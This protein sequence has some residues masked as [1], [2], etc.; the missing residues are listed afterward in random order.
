MPYQGYGQDSDGDGIDDISDLDS[1][2]DGIL[3]TEEGRCA[4]LSFTFDTDNEGWIEDNGNDGSTGLLIN[5]STNPI[6]VTGG[7][8]LMGAIPTGPSGDYIIQDDHASNNMFFES[9]DNLNIDLSNE[10]NVGNLSFYWI[11]G[12]YD[13]SGGQSGGVDMMPVVLVGGGTSV[14]ATFDVTGLDNAGV[15]TQFTFPLDDATWSGTLAD[16]TTVLSDLDR[17]EIRVESITSHNFGSGGASCSNAEWFGLDEII[18]SCT[19]RDTDG[20][21]VPDYLDLD[22]DNDGILDIV[23]AGGEDTDNDGRVDDDT[24]TDGDG[25]A[26]TFDSDDGGTAL[27][28]PNT[29]G[30]GGPDYLDIDA[31]GDGI[32]DN[33]EGQSSGGYI[34]PTGTDS[35]GDGIDD[36]YDIDAGGTPIDPNDHDGDGTPDYQDLDSDNDGEPDLLEGH[37][38]DGDGVA[39]T[40]PTGTDSDGDGLDDAFDTVVLDP[41]T[42]FTNAGNG[43]TDPLT[44]GVLADADNPGFADLDFRENDTD[45]DGIDDSVDLDDDNDGILDIAEGDGD[46]DGDGIPDRLDLDSDN[47]GIPDIVEAGGTDADG[48]GRVDDDTDTDG[49]GYADTFDPDDGGTELENPDSDGDGVSD[50]TDLDS[51]NDGTPDLVEAGGTDADGDGV[52]DDPTDTNGDGLADIVDT[53]DG[54]TPLDN[55]DTDT[56]GVPDVLDLDSDNDGIADVIEKRWKQML[57]EME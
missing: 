11:N 41:A 22:S 28:I 42:S 46:T 2:N 17:I 56:D 4:E 7:C 29:D 26:D 37:D 25:Y 48:D 57:T 27:D 47:D 53:D 43:T 23:E 13:G 6:S 24:D 5:H 1:D 10:I 40:V 30:T 34:P 55:P 38:L 31:D 45:G 12:T 16:L 44:D 33:I 3:D 18:F 21:G 14:T 35:D 15:W 36:A 50:A 49:D 39:D 20:D 51:D 54:G 8:T 32:V 9:P 19:D 52:V